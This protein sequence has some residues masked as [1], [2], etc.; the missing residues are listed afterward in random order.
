[1][2][3]LVPCVRCGGYHADGACPFVPRVPCLLCGG[4]HG[5]GGCPFVPQGW[6]IR[7]N[8]AALAAARG[9]EMPTVN[10]PPL[11]GT[12]GSEP[13][14]RQRERRHVPTRRELSVLNEVQ[15]LRSAL[16]H[17]LDALSWTVGRFEG[18]GEPVPGHVRSSYMA[19]RAALGLI[20]DADAGVRTVEREQLDRLDPNAWEAKPP[21]LEVDPAQAEALADRVARD[22]FGD[23]RVAE[24]EREQRADLDAR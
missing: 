14:R 18:A 22:V 5:Y 15:R 19:V 16:G 2:S 11:P 7:V 23:N 20:S 8:P 9:A 17:A 4:H 10:D 24:P 21:E 3:T 1:M 12:E 6:I 13:A